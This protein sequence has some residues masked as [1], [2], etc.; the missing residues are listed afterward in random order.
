MGMPEYVCLK[1]I[2]DKVGDTAEDRISSYFIDLVKACTSFVASLATEF[3]TTE[4]S[5]LLSGSILPISRDEKGNT[6]HYNR[7]LLIQLYYY[8]L[9]SQ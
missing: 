6:C 9:S 2:V 7:S 5:I 4:M 1:S 3:D 8:E